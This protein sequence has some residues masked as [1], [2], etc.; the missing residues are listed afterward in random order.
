MDNPWVEMLTKA[1]AVS[2]SV[3]L[4]DEVYLQ[5]GVG[6]E[7][8]FCERCVGRWNHWVTAHQPQLAG[9]APQKFYQRAHKYPA[10]YEAWLQSVSYTHLTLPTILLV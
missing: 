4:D 2:S 7:I 1:A 5:S 9:P 10:H 8:C 6:P 3:N